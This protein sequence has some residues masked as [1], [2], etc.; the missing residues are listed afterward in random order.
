V[1]Q[2]EKTILIPV[3]TAESNGGGLRTGNA[4][5]N[6]DLSPMLKTTSLKNINN[7]YDFG[8]AFNQTQNLPRQGAVSQVTR[9]SK[10]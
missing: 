7:D 4:S 2:Q 8:G 10:E 3:V 1:R 5:P 9:T 6:A